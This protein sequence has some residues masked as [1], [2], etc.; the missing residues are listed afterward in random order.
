MSEQLN[1]MPVY[2]VNQD[3]IDRLS[4]RVDKLRRVSTYNY[5]PKNNQRKIR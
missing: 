4:K 3:Y 1:E 5:K 2:K